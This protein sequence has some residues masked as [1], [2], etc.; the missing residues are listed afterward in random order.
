M[1]AVELAV[2]GTISAAVIC[3]AAAETLANRA[4]WSVAALL[5]LIHSAAA[6]MIFYDGQHEIARVETARQTAALTGIAFTGGIYVNYLFLVVWTADAV[7]WLL[8]SDSYARRSRALSL[9]IRGFIFFII[10]NG[11]VV[12]ADGWARI[13]GVVSVMLV[14]ASWFLRRS[15]RLGAS[16]TVG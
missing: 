3:W 11:A 6:F 7:W 15:S 16:I 4:L 14:V 2:F 1:S 10:L 5:A 8:A 9:A 13:V 12:F